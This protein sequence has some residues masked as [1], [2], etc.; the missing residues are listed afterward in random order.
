MKKILSFFI[1]F[2]VSFFL[3]N[4][5]VK[6]DDLKC[7]YGTFD[8]N[9][10]FTSVVTMIIKSDGTVD[11]DASS[12]GIQ[13]FGCQSDWQTATTNGTTGSG[14]LYCG[15]VSVGFLTTEMK[16]KFVFYKMGSSISENRRDNEKGIC[17]RTIQM[18]KEV[19]E[20]NFVTY[21]L[22]GQKYK[23]E[24]LS[25]Y[26]DDLSEI[27]SQNIIKNWFEGLFYTYDGTVT[28]LVEKNQEAPLEYDSGCPTY[29]KYLNYYLPDSQSK[30]SG[31]TCDSNPYF[32]DDYLR[33]S[34]LCDNYRSSVTDYV[35]TSDSNANSNSLVTAKKCMTAC[36]AL[37]DDVADL[38]G[39][40]TQ[41]HYCGSLGNKIVNW[42]IKV[43]KIVRYGVPVMLIILSALDYIRAIAADSEDEM[44]KV[45][46]RLGK[47]L[48]AAALIFILPAILDF[49][50]KS[51][52]IP[53]LNASN[54]F[55]AK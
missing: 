38:C 10:N 36:S 30:V 7:E 5:V 18:R 26:Q 55:C 11:V 37:K 22:T 4:N 29:D 31:N 15:D 52:D 43:I 1:A 12:P 27:E 14:G 42:L 39:G 6:A 46:S 32:T 33:I 8:D 35:T 48:L 13:S 50:L 54:P 9:H 23:F 17:S 41:G 25:F 44:K 47:R 45:S 16:L 53:G 34:E 19:N 51:F 40:T 3:F 24:F 21:L 20:N 49:I 28:T 2:I